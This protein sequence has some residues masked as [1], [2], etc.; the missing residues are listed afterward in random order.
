MS[1]G[2]L[3]LLFFLHFHVICYMYN[4]QLEALVLAAFL[5]SFF[6][7]TRWFPEAYSSDHRARGLRL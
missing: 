3:L 1:F 6:I 5:S 2:F 7:Q 4:C